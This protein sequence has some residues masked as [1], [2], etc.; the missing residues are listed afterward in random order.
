MPESDPITILLVEDNPADI[1]LT[2]DALSTWKTPHDLQI[3]KDGESAVSY[4]EKKGSFRDAPRP[5]LVL[6][7]LNLPRMDGME[8]LRSMR[9]LPDLEDL[10]V[11][12]ISTSVDDR[13]ITEGY[14]LAVASYIAKSDEPAVFRQSIKAVE[15]MVVSRGILPR[16]DEEFQTLSALSVLHVEDNPGDARLMEEMLRSETEGELKLRTVNK[17]ANASA[18]V[19]AGSVDVILLDLFLP[20]SQGT[21]TLTTTLGFAPNIPVVVV[22]GLENPELAVEAIKLGAQDCLF[23][24]DLTASLV[25]RVLRH[26]FERKQLQEDLRTGEEQLREV[27]SVMPDGV[28]VLDKGGQV[29]FANPAAEIMLGRNSA[30]LVGSEFGFP[31]IIGERGEIELVSKG[32]GHIISAELNCS[33]IMWEQQPALLATM[34]DMTDRLA[35]AR[36]TQQAR[37]DLEK[38][39]E[40]R[41][42]DLLKAN[43]ELL[44]ADR[45]KSMFLASMS[46]ELRTPLNAIIGFTGVILQGMSG[47]ISQEQRKQ[48]TMVKNSADHLL[49]LI[50]DIIDISK[51]EAGALTLSKEQ[52]ELTG[53]LKGVLDIFKSHARSKGLS[54]GF[55]GPDTFPAVNDPK[56]LRQVAINLVGNAV[57]FTGEGTVTVRLE[58]D[59][60]RGVITVTDSG[61]GIDSEERQ[62]VFEPFYK[63][64][65]LSERNQEG[66]GIGLYLSRKMAALLG[67]NISVDGA[68]GGGSVFT[69]TFSV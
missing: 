68:P 17:L 43:E 67:G 57:K 39:V 63:S 38:L 29:L 30:E 59:G 49:G 3:V 4:L 48:L 16:P 34:R 8:V 33:R 36:A 61:P 22:T 18:V 45:L 13:D 65:S 23:K 15:E 7:D 10:P 20:D 58:R 25:Q 69:F 35:A 62:R 64:P 14:G 2:R 37:D 54:L 66:T 6:L 47:D 26:A 60:P 24:G 9:R 12:I 27:I 44:R 52:V 46:H 42:A 55:S 50:N 40:V 53:L 5:H 56:R 28:V 32:R 1:V 11:V 19:A 21:A 41:T 51:I 31:A